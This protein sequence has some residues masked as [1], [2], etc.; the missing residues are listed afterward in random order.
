VA[1]YAQVTARIGGR[2]YARV[3]TALRIREVHA[4]F[5]RLLVTAELLERRRGRLRGR[6][7]A[8]SIPPG[9]HR[10]LLIA[11]RDFNRSLDELAVRT[12]ARATR[13]V[14]SQFDAS[15]VRRNT[16]MAPHLRGAIRSRPLRPLGALGTGTVGIGDI[17]AL[18]RVTNLTSPGYG[19]YWR[20]QEY[21]TGGRADLPGDPAYGKTIPAQA[22][23]VIRGHFFGP[24][25]TD[26]DVPRA[27]YAGGGGPHPIFVSARS[28]RAIRGGVGFAGGGGRRGGLGGLGTIRKEIDGGHFIREGADRARVGWWREMRRIEGQTTGRILAITRQR[29][30][31][32]GGGRRLRRR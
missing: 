9:M 20:A 10:E 7:S 27:V 25:L 32:L 12:A 21:G 5:D 31:G 30:G 23:R 14:K 6:L 8:R 3:F 24:G 11:Y 4:K 17:R 29:V 16:R 2:E 1:G 22:G 19:P 18:D 15:R 13:I 28:A 26:P